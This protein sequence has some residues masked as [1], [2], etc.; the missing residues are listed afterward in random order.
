MSD[1]TKEVADPVGVLTLAF[2]TSTTFTP[3]IKTIKVFGRD[4]GG[5]IDMSGI[6]NTAW[7]TKAAKVLKDVSSITG[8]AFLDFSEEPPINVEQAI[9]L[10]VNAIGDWTVYGYLNTFEPQDADDDQD[11][12]IQYDY[13]IVI[14][15]R[16]PTTL[17][18]TGPAF[19]A[20][21]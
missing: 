12:G 19:A 5:P 9:T 20:A 8:S 17:A 7:R 14:T 15:N 21:T 13:E 10:G 11:E 4:G 16:H 1:I 3:R 6:A 18:E 2:G